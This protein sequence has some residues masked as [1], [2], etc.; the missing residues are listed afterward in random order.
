MDF[1]ALLKAN[2]SYSV[3]T[4]VLVDRDAPP[5]RS[6]HRPTFVVALSDRRVS[7]KSL[8]D[9]A[10]TQVAQLGKLPGF[11]QVSFEPGAGS[12]EERH[13]FQDPTGATLEQR[14]Y[15]RVEG[16][17][18]LVA[19]VTHLAG[20]PFGEAAAGFAPLLAAAGFSAG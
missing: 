20:V 12:V 1:G 6:G 3:Q 19:T 14:Q 18:A 15:F 2:P 4:L 8:E 16:D 11:R 13:T 10:R 7:E 9:Y 5:T 17:R